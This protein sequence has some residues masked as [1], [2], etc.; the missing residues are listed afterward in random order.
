MRVTAAAALIMLMLLTSFGAKAQ[1]DQSRF[2]HGYDEYIP[3]PGYVPVPGPIEP[4][5]RVYAL[6]DV[7][8]VEPPSQPPKSDPRCVELT[9][10]QRTE[11]PGC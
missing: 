5:P 2:P 6:P 1:V 10:K 7:P 11:T 4:P 9:P 3:I 8:Q